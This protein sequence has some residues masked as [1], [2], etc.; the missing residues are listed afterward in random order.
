MLDELRPE[1]AE[2]A[3][4]VVA[5]Q[6]LAVAGG[7]GAD[8]DGRHRHGLGDPPRQRLDHALDHHGE[9]AG[10]RD[11]L[12]VGDDPLGLGLAFPRAP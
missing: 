4:H 5:D 9:G 2:Q 10:L 3:Q 1:V 8:A 6:D 7:R 11:R 12:R